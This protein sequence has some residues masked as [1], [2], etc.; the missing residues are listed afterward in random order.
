MT[1]GRTINKLDHLPAAA[2]HQHIETL[3]EAQFTHDIVREVTE[4]IAHILDGSLL[5]LSLVTLRLLLCQSRAKLSNMQQHDI[6][7]ALESL[8]GES[9]AQ[10]PSLP[11]MDGLIDDIV[12]V[13]H[14]LNRSEPIVEIGLLQLLPMSIDI[15]Q[16]L[17]GIDG[18][19][20]RRNTHMRSILLMQIMQP[21]MPVPLQAMIQLHPGGYRRKER[22][23]KFPKRMQEAVVD[24]I[25]KRLCNRNSKH[26]DDVHCTYH[27]PPMNNKRGTKRDEEG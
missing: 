1:V 18:D 16:T 11:T 23:V 14:A 25:C 12:R 7:H 24:D 20:V 19:K 15:M 27:T 5:S 9:L 13:I 10:H 2:G 26:C 17:R 6:F 21:Q 4:P 22:T 8:I 3:P